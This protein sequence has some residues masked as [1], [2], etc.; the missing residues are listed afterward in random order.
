MKRIGILTFWGVENQGTFAQAYALQR[1]LAELYPDYEVYQIGYLHEKHLKFYEQFYK[2]NCLNISEIEK[3]SKLFKNCYDAIPHITIE[4]IEQLE[5]EEFD[6]IVLGSDIIWDYMLDVFGHDEHLFGVGMNAP[7]KVSYASSFGTCIPGKPIPDYV[8]Q[9]M[10]ELYKISVRDEKSAQIVKN[11][12]G[13]MPVVVLD[14]V[15]MWDF[16]ND[17]NIKQDVAEKEYIFVYGSN[18]AEKFKEEL[19]EFANSHNKKLVALET[20][21]YDFG[22]CHKTVSP[23]EKN[24]L[25]VISYFLHA[26]YIATNTYH[27]MMFSLLFNKRVAY[28]KT[29]FIMAKISSLL[30]DLNLQFL[31]DDRNSVTDVYEYNWNYNEIM[32][33]I[34]SKRAQSEHFLKNLLEK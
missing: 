4:T 24:P 17:K 25:D 9:G 32:Q 16:K 27:G 8:K 33:I 13:V 21:S 3:R 23:A 1:K 20:F 12:I 28:E 6:M 14:P 22:W 5:N 31:I 30:S 10:Q 26:D 29:D 15:W 7:K 2:N 19:I 18:F 34:E 11:N